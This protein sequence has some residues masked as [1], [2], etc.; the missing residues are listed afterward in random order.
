VTVTATTASSGPYSPDGSTTVFPFSFVALS[1]AE[2][3]VV[4]RPDAG[5]DAVLVGYSVSLNANQVTSPGG[6]V[7][8]SVAP[9]VGDPLYV[10]SNPDFTQQV[11]FANQGDWSPTS[12]NTALDRAAIRAIWAKD[13]IATLTA[14]VDAVELANVDQD[15]AIAA[16]YDDSRALLATIT[17]LLTAAPASPFPIGKITLPTAFNNQLGIAPYWNG[18]AIKFIVH[19]YDLIDFTLTATTITDYYLKYTSP[20]SDTNNGTTSGT[21]FKTWDHLLS[22]VAGL[23][24]GS[25]V[26]VHLLDD[27]VGYLSATAG[28]YAQFDG[29]NVKVIGEGPSGRTKFVT[30]RETYNQAAFGF[31]A[32]GSNG[33]WKSNA[34]GVVNN[35]TLQFYVNGSGD[36]IPIPIVSTGQSAATVDTTELTSFWDGTWLYVHLPGGVKPN[37]FVNWEWS[38]NALGG[39]TY[40]SDSGTVL[41]ENVSYFT[42]ARGATFNCLNTRS[43]LDTNFLSQARLGLRNVYGYGSSGNI[44]GLKDWHIVAVDQC[45]GA[46]A[47]NDIFNYHTNQNTGTHGAYI[48]IY[49]TDTYGTDA[50]YSGFNDGVSAGT[51]NNGSTAHDSINILRANTAY[52]GGEGAVV[53]DVNGVVSVNLNVRT[54]IPG[55]TAVPKACFWH[56]GTGWGSSYGMYLWGC[57]A[58]DGGDT[59]VILLDNAG[60]PNGEAN[61]QIYVKYWRGQTT[62]TVVGTL[63]D[64]S[65]NTLANLAAAV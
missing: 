38:N 57:S 4:R 12:I 61:G 45:Q 15:A 6:S 59:S 25:N 42:S 1:A 46:Y 43:V 23:A 35:F 18:A 9:A 14:A 27:Y 48:T 8:F 41:F 51:S 17:D 11:T 53:A 16:Q 65:G 62:G 36:P 32:H 22:V 24:S 13:R 58:F 3:Q 7:T 10:L 30:M 50:G 39:H 47:R 44:F 26:R 56:S 20:G 63:K 49:E 60:A 5:A 54:G 29:K 31:V 19:P 37:P 52:A 2:V 21:P 33:A 34:A 40:R 28:N 64:W 55:S